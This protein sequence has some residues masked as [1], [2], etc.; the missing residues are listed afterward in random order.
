M[1]VEQISDHLLAASQLRIP[2]LDPNESPGLKIG[3]LE[4]YMLQVAYHR[5]D[6]EEAIGWVL[7]A[8]HDARRTLDG[9]QGWE[10]TVPRQADRTQERVLEAKARIAP[11]P[12]AI[13]RDSDYYLKRLERQ[14]RRLE[15]DHNAVSRAYTLITGQA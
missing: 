5:G 15:L 10:Q 8:K 7:E 12:V 3:K 6:L 1:N 9:V 13:L 11:E 2:K 14:V 4:E